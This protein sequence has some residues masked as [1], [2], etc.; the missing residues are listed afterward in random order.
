MSSKF[1][2]LLGPLL[3]AVVGQITGTSR[4]SIISLIV[5]FIVGGLVLSRVDE[6]AGVRVARSADADALVIEARA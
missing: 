5:F 1:A 4:L 3:F 2:G 6:E